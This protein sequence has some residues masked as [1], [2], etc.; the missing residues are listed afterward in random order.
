ML[1]SW[2]KYE[3]ADSPSNLNGSEFEN[4][5]AFNVDTYGTREEKRR[6]VKYLPVHGTRVPR[7]TRS[8]TP[9]TCTSN[10]TPI[11]FSKKNPFGNVHF[12]NIQWI[13]NYQNHLKGKWHRNHSRSSSSP[14]TR[15]GATGLPPN[16]SPPNS[17]S[18]TPDQPTTSST[19]LPKMVSHPTTNSSKVTNI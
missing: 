11:E 18:Y 7:Q 5:T 3:M 16:P 19:S 13:A 12:G 8:S 15:A 17:N 14:A 10:K 2:K 9:N 1:A 4:S 6:K